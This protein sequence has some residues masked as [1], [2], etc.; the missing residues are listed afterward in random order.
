MPRPAKPEIM[1]L[2]IEGVIASAQAV[3]ERVRTELP[4]HQGLA[5][6]AERVALVAREAERVSRDVQKPWSLHRLPAVFLAAA[7]LILG[8]WIYWR[9]FHVS[10]LS[11]A[12]PDRDASAIRERVSTQAR[13][14]LRSVGVPGSQEAAQ[15]VSHGK[16]DLAFVQGGIAIPHDLPRLESPSPEIVLWM[17]RDG[18]TLENVRRVLTSLSGEGSH[19]VARDF[20]KAWKIGDQATF[21][22][23][24]R[25][26]STNADYAI[27]ADV[28]AVFVVKDPAD[29]KTLFAVE[30]LVEAGFQFRSPNLGV[31]AARL[32]Y[33]RPTTVPAGY[34]SSSPP[35]PAEPMPTYHVT[36]FLVARRGLTPRLL[37]VAG[38]VFDSKPATIAEGEYLPTA[39]DAG[40]IF[41]GVEAFLGIIVNIGLAF[42]ALLGLEMMTY[43]K[44]F[45]ELNSLVSLLSMLQSNKDVLGL[46]D[47]GILRE[48]LLYLGL[49][50]DLLGLVSM[51]SGYYTQENS[52][53]L[54]NN[55]SE[56]IHE[57]CDSLKINIQLKILHA[58]INLP[59]SKPAPATQSLTQTNIA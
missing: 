12:L 5:G 57:R 43:R 34:L 10:T 25:E 42:L 3:A 22:H 9:F 27:P 7:L 18:V 44:R 21:L 11:I 38:H 36:T 40:D 30:R 6:A 46:R 28:D 14:D 39:S 52:S 54:F 33:L 4:T 19:T 59:D 13:V 2:K 23:D 50:S 32:D 56:V 1:R 58:A 17:L 45:H 31:Q 53:L 47:G 51:I 49:T 20:F 55:L 35:L 41:Q 24:W 8:L 26:L 37:A 15:L 29:E 48:N 16:V